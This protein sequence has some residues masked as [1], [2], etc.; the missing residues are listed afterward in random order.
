MGSNLLDRF[1]RQHDLLDIRESLDLYGEKI[2]CHNA[3]YGL[4]GANTREEIEEHL[5]DCLLPWPHLPLSRHSRAFDLGSGSGMPGIPLALASR[6]QGLDIHWILVERSAKK[7]RFL[8]HVLAALG[9]HEVEVFAGEARDLGSRAD[10]AVCR[11]FLPLGRELVD[12]GRSL[13]NDGGW[14]GYYAAR[15][16]GWIDFSGEAE[17]IPLEGGA[18]ERWIVLIRFSSANSVADPC[19]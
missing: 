14:L 6:A 19:R 12:L 15:R 7:A 4:V 16:E 8:E 10:A 5:L 3:R 17:A 13:V 2:L 11:A 1:L 9:L 18:K